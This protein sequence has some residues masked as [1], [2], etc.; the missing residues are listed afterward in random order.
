MEAINCNISED[1]LAPRK[2][3]SGITIDCE[4]TLD[5]DDALWLVRDGTNYRVQ[6]SIS[7]VASLVDKGSET[8][9]EALHRILTLYLAG[10][11]NPMLPNVLSES[12]LSLVA[13][14]F[15]PTLTFTVTLDNYAN[16]LEYEIEQTCLLSQQKMSYSQVSDILANKEVETGLE[17]KQMLQDMSVVGSRLRSKRL[18]G[19]QQADNLSLRTDL[20]VPELMILTNH[21]SALHLHKN[22]VPSI[23]RNHIPSVNSINKAYYNHCNHGHEGLRLNAYTHATSPLRRYPD[24]IVHRQLIS[25]MNSSVPSYNSQDTQML[26]EYFNKYLSYRDEAFEEAFSSKHYVWHKQRQTLDQVPE[27]TFNEV[28][29][30]FCKLP[31]LQ[32]DFVQELKKRL[33]QRTIKHPVVAA[34]L[35]ESVEES[36]HWRKVRSHIKSYIDANPKQAYYILLEACN[37]HYA[38]IEKLQFEIY[39]ANDKTYHSRILLQIDSQI[40]GLEAPCSSKKMN[41]SKYRAASQVLTALLEKKLIETEYNLEISGLQV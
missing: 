31:R 18:G 15:R 24:L 35:F 8:D 27:E 20:I 23:F 6:I 37:K 33:F 12:V 40:Y 36:H 21:I 1:L 14:E 4:E 26:A 19:H 32:P 34:C 3:V 2:E 9:K 41:T 13:G 10:A 11:V 28:L 29:I 5:I 17:H 39:R 38:G 22:Q 30:K 25:T 16:I 7:D